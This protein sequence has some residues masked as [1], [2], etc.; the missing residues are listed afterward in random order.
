MKKRTKTEVLLIVSLVFTAVITSIYAFFFFSMKE[1]TGNTA[2]LSAKVEQLSGDEAKLA[3]SV[4][5]FKAEDVRIEKLQ[6]YFIKESEIVAF[7]KKIEELGAQ[8]GAA[9]SIESLES[10]LSESKTPILNFRI[11]ATG[12]FMEVM[13]VVT[14]LE[15]F[16]AKFEWKNIRLVRSGAEPVVVK[17]VSRVPVATPLWGLDMTVAALNFVRE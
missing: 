12:K 7:A 6:S 9:L 16:P 4:S 2:G 10:G 5:A 8:S 3:A 1:K 11:K 14:L 17:G 13:H 15:N